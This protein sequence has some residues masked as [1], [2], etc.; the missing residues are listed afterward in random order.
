M[1][2][3]HL[4]LLAATVVA[5]GPKPRPFI[6]AGPDEDAGFDAGEPDAGRNKGVEPPTGYSVALELPSGNGPSVRV[7]VSA[8]MALDQF[9]HPMIAALYTDP[10][11]DGLHIDDSLV[12]TRWNGF[13]KTA[14]GGTVGYQKAATI[15]SVGE[16]DLTEPNRQVSLTRDPMTGQIGIAYIN[17]QKLV[18]VALS[19]DEGATWS[20]ET[21]NLTNTS[22]HLLSNPALVI[23]NGV[24][25]VAYFEAEAPCGTADCGQVIYRKRT[26]KAAFSDATSPAPA[27]TDVTLAKPIALAVDSAGN[28]GIAYFTGPTG[29]ASGPVS[30]LFWRP[31]GIAT[32]KIADS[33]TAVIA[34]SKPPSV[35]LTFSDVNPRV[36]YHLPSSAVPAAQ[37]WYAAAT[38]AAGSTF[39]PIEIPRN[40]A[41]ANFDS[42]TT[43]QSIALDPAGKIAIAANHNSSTASQGCSGGPKLSRSSN[44]T[45]FTT[46][47]PDTAGS[48]GVFGYAGLWITAAFHKADK[49]TL[50]FTY[51]DSGNPTVKAGVIVFRQP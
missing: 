15:A 32:T 14:D 27:G 45:T 26:G 49:V 46:C 51:E 31:S 37:L 18:K 39:T 33:G 9:S 10:N 36:A 2:K 7:G 19:N 38:D 3:L 20:L 47:R 40:M 22:G 13:D 30:L 12:F 16:I 24:T 17:E 48:S 28:A 43:F 42:T 4:L 1:N 29:A 21:V 11:N 35:S 41:G 8:S 25:H 34:A 23:K 5:C 50:A 44:G 6:D